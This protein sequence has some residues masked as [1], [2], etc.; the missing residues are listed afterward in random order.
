MQC[1]SAINLCNVFLYFSAVLMN[2]DIHVCLYKLI[3]PHCTTPWSSQKSKSVTL[4][5][6]HTHTHTHAGSGINPCSSANG[7]CSHLCLISSYQST[8]YSCSCPEG[9]SLGNDQRTCFNSSSA[10]PST[11]ASPQGW[12]RVMH[13]LWCFFVLRWVYDMTQ[14]V[15]F[16]VRNVTQE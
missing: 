6:H 7:N 2:Y 16:L 4:S 12:N 5:F 11:T 15:T 14:E 3:N 8:G 1:E 10:T 9:M 13:G